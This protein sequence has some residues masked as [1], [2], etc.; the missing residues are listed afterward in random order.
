MPKYKA[1]LIDKFRA[2]LSQKGSRGLIGLQRAFKMMDTDQSGGLDE[3]EFS[4]A[5]KDHGVE[6][7]QAD[8]RGLFK[9]FDENGDGIISHDEFINTVK[10]PL[11]PF[12]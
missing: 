2:K 5:I 10:G 8:L 9:A 12:R 1:I 11:N 6:I 4:N 7:N 3:Y